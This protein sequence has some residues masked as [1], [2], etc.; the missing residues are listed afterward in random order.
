M[1]S[2]IEAMVRELHDR[3]AIRD[4][5]IRYCRG[6]DRMDRA[7]VLSCY[8]PEAIDDHGLF[9][10]GPEA[11]VDWAFALH[12]H[13]QFA[14]QHIVTNHSC[15]LDGDTAHTETYWMF[16]GMH[17]E[18]AK[19][20][21]GGGRYIDRMERRLGEWRIAARKCIPDW[22]GQPTESW[23]SPEASAALASGGTAARNNSDVSYERPLTI[24]PERI[25]K[26]F[27]L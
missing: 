15:E 27:A 4:V 13:V 25:G 2:E 21:I 14:H 23:L 20:T 1:G 9:V 5:V 19:L 18:G 16:A 26:I 8:H 12:T 10:G 17:H 6:V 11:F 3:Q 24:D 22:G 7:L